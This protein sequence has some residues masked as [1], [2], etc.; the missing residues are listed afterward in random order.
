MPA[1]DDVSI[2]VRDIVFT[3]PTGRPVTLRELPGIRVVVLMRHRH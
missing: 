3:D 2:D 1:R